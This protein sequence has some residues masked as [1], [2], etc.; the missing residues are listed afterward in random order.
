MTIHQLKKTKRAIE[1]FCYKVRFN[2]GLHQ[3]LKGPLYNNLKDQIKSA[4]KKQILFFAKVEKVNYVVGV[5][6]AVRT[7]TATDLLDKISYYWIPM[8]DLLDSSSF[9]DYIKSAATVGGQAGIGKLGAEGTFIVQDSSL[10]SSL[11]KRAKISLNEVDVTTQGWI[12]RTIEEGFKKGLSSIEIAQL[13]HNNAERVASERAEAIVEYEGTLA[14]DITEQEFYRKNGVKHIKWITSHDELTCI[15]CIAN[16]E[17]GSMPVDGVFP[18]GV[19]Q[20]PQHPRCRCIIIPV[21]KVDV[22]WMG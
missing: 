14:Y 9:T 15:D 8:L 3:A 13:L 5:Q 10:L 18:G 2:V 20:P 6:K 19:G 4:L 1:A 11:E 17:V 16:E 12:A 7:L 22:V 21:D